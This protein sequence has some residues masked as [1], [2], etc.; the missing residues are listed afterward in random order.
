MR[1]GLLGLAFAG[2]SVSALNAYADDK[3][4]EEA[5]KKEV[6][7]LKGSWK[8]VSRVVD[9]EET[10]AETIKN[11]VITFEGAKYVIRDGETAKYASEFKIDLAHDPKWFDIPDGD[12]T[13]LGIYKIDGN[14]VTF[15]LSKP[16]GPRPTDFTAKKGSDRTMTVYK[17]PKE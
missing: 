1:M 8:I 16:G 14:T 17:K 12:K 13:M 7:T 10:P 9:G 3:A 11:R 4:T 6:D 15:C 5:I 2:I